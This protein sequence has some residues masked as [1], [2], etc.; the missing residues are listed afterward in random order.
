MRVVYLSVS[1]DPVITGWCVMRGHEAGAGSGCEAN[2]C[3][4]TTSLEV[5]I[6]ESYEHNY[7]HI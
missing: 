3:L 5:F 4:F 1:R 2:F 6:H 7:K